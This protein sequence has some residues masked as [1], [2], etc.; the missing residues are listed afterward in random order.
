MKTSAGREEAGSSWIRDWTRDPRIARRLEYVDLVRVMGIEARQGVCDLTLGQVQE[1]LV[2]RVTDGAYV[3]AR[4]IK[5]WRTEL[6]R[7]GA[8]ENVGPGLRGSKDGRGRGRGGEWRLLEHP[9]RKR[10]TQGREEAGKPLAPPIST[11]TKELE[12]E[13]SRR[14]PLMVDASKASA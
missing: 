7:L 12:P 8:I 9:E 14:R 10:A 2:T 6:K 11:T 1:R 4:T 13:G 3:P 5:S